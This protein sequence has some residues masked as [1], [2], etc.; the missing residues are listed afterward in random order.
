VT[1]YFAYISRHLQRPDNW[2][3][4]WLGFPGKELSIASNDG[5]TCMIE[6]SSRDTSCIRGNVNEMTAKRNKYFSAISWRFSSRIILPRIFQTLFV[7]DIRGNASINRGVFVSSANPWHDDIRCILWSRSFK[8]S[9]SVFK[10]K[11]SALNRFM[12]PTKSTL[13]NYE[14]W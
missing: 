8:F 2:I 10:L 9:L 6:F 1:Y 7:Q 4:G 5:S 3:V 12:L 13:L 11:I 14:H